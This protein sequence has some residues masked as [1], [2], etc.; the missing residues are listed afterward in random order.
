[1]AHH[2]VRYLGDLSGGQVVATHVRRH[3]G[4]TDGLTF[5]DFTEVGKPKPYKDDYRAA[6][7]G[8]PLTSDQRGS[9]LAEAVEAFRA[10][11][12]VFAELAS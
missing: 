3:Y 1:M 2:Y 5:Y 11:Q 10:N 8:L 6:L 4:L 7:D 9:V 12:A